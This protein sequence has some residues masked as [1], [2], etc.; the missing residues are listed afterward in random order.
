MRS[1]AQELRIGLRFS[2]LVSHLCMQI[3]GMHT[4]TTLFGAPSA[5]LDSSRRCR[6]FANVVL[7]P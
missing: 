4:F 3:Y 5:I 6:F 2:V 7:F 1:M